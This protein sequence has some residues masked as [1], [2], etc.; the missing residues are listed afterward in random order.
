VLGRSPP[1]ANQTSFAVLNPPLSRAPPGYTSTTTL[2]RWPEVVCTPTALLVLNSVVPLLG[3]VVTS[4]SSWAFSSAAVVAW[5]ACRACGVRGGPLP[6]VMRTTAKVA[7]PTTISALPS[8]ITLN[9]V[10]A[11]PSQPRCHA[12][13]FALT[14]RKPRDIWDDPVI[15]SGALLLNFP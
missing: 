15:C 1:V 6:V 7:R 8:K 13:A 12:L 10:L 4:A 3:A 5:L 2:A 11:C 14:P 9:V